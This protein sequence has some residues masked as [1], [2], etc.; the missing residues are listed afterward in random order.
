MKR[1]ILIALVF[2]VSSSP[3]MIF[4]GQGE[5]RADRIETLKI[6]K[7]I[8]YLQLSDTQS[9]KFLPRFRNFENDIRKIQMT[10]NKH[11]AELEKKIKSGNTKGIDKNIDVILNDDIKMAQQKKDFFSSIKGIITEEQMAK[12]IVFEY[13]FRREIRQMIERRA[14]MRKGFLRR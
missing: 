14:N 7:L 4:A 9:D 12:M 5:T 1:L 8:N 6:W 13:Q 3:M 11:V 10:K 2:V